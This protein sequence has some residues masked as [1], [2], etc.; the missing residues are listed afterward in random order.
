[1][2]ELNGSETVNL[3]GRAYSIRYQNHQRKKT[4]LESGYYIN[5]K[6]YIQTTGETYW[7]QVFSQKNSQ[8]WGLVI[9]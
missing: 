5:R 7:N 8:R 3:R 4:F 9:S 2:R 6:I 1:M